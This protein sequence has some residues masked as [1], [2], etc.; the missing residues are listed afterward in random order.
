MIMS[1]RT[2]CV[3]LKGVKVNTLIPP[4]SIP[5]DPV[6]PEPAEHRVWTVAVEV[7]IGRVPVADVIRQLRFYM[8]YTRAELWALATP[9]PV[10]AHEMKSLTDS[11]IKHIL[12]GDAFDE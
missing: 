11:G 8:T 3:K 5:P 12:L 2:V 10:N 9:W 7:K 4:A 6:P 1:D